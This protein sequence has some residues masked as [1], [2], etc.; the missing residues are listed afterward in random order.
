MDAGNSPESLHDGPVQGEQSDITNQTDTRPIDLTAPS[1]QADLSVAVARAAE[2]APEQTGWTARRRALVFGGGTL[3]L[4][5][6]TAGA[7]VAVT[8]FL[9]GSRER[10]AADGPRTG[11]DPVASAGPFESPAAEAPVQASPAPVESQPAVESRA[12]QPQEGTPDPRPTTDK[13]LLPV[14]PSN[15]SAE[16]RARAVFDQ[17]LIMWRNQGIGP[18]MPRFI[19]GSGMTVDKYASLSAELIAADN[20]KSLFIRGWDHAPDLIQYANDL[21]AQHERTIALAYLTRN[22]AVPFAWSTKVLSVNVSTDYGNQ[23]NGAI[24]FYQYNN[25]DQNTAQDIFP[26]LVEQDGQKMRIA[27][28]MLRDGSRMHISALQMYELRDQSAS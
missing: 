28:K 18:S 26:D 24:D 17:A 3:G 14:I 22:D 7:T 19:Q 23:L 4:I 27:F 21:K 9:G 20:S 6:V 16:A 5:A 8:G 12:P 11:A 13:Y 2:T 1:E 25:A 15:I 10:T